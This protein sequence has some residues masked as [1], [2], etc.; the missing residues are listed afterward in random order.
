MHCGC[1]CAW[2]LNLQNACPLCRGNVEELAMVREL[3][4]VSVAYEL[5]VVLRK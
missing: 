3:V 4:V 1:G 2:N 5:R